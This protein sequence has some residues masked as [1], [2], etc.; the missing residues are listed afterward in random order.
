MVVL[1]DRE[2]EFPVSSI[3]N[4]DNDD[5]AADDNDADDFADVERRNEGRS[6]CANC[7][8]INEKSQC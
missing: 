6:G 8:E 1:R 5:A 7:I 4:V 2:N 3:D